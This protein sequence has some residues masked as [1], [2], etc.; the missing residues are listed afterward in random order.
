MPRYD[1]GADGRLELGIADPVGG[2]E[3][4]ATLGGRERDRERLT[5]DAEL[6]SGAVEG[7]KRELLCGLLDSV[8]IAPLAGSAGIGDRR[9]LVGAAAQHQVEGDEGRRGRDGDADE[10]AAAHSC[11]RRRAIAIGISATRAKAAAI[12][13]EALNACVAAASTSSSI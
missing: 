2:G 4:L 11:T 3:L 1:P 7:R 13:N 8:R 10:R 6:A 9:G 12:R 5:A